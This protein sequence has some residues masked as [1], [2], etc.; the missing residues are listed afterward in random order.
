MER[1]RLEA[2]RQ[3]DLEKARREADIDRA[4]KKKAQ[5]EKRESRERIER[6]RIAAQIARDNAKEIRV[7]RA[8]DL[9][10]RA[11]QPIPKCPE[12]IPQ[13][14][15]GFESQ[16][17]LNGIADDIWL[18]LLNQFLTDKA[19]RLVDRL[20]PD[21]VDTYDKLRVSILRE[22]DLTPNAYRKFFE[23]AVKTEG[24]TWV[25][26]CTRLQNRLKYYLES[27]DV[28]HDFDR[29]VLLLVSD[30]LKSLVPSSLSDFIRQRELDGWVDPQALARS[31]DT[32]IADRNTA[33]R[34]ASAVESREG[35]W[36]GG[37][38]GHREAGGS[39]EPW[40]PLEGGSPHHD[41]TA[42]REGVIWGRLQCPHVQPIPTLIHQ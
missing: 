34:G 30:R 15:M 1:E 38:G 7:K 29:L 6:E 32:F 37:R 13:W 26:L 12:D 25:Q 16:L 3:E 39:I 41:V 31:L 14:F 28:K 23:H 10:H 33:G 17:K 18:P 20:T 8:S 35:G 42:S 9:L 4:E 40:L 24:E 22:Y 21:Q 19:R 11:I 36:R 5:D 27:R 2:L